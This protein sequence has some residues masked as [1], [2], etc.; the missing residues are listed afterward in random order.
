MK[1]HV[2]ATVQIVIANVVVA[3]RTVAIPIPRGALSDEVLEAFT[4]QAAVKVLPTITVSD[5]GT[6]RK[7]IEVAARDPV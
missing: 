4:K 2:D 1:T 6:L 5:P 7:A 3:T